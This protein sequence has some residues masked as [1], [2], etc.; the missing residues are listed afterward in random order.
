MVLENIRWSQSARVLVLLSISCL[1]ATVIVWGATRSSRRQADQAKSDEAQTKAVQKLEGLRQKY[2]AVRSV[3]IAAKAIIHLDGANARSGSGSYEYWAD[4][5]RYRIKCYTDPHLELVS[6]TEFAYDGKRFYFLDRK[7]GIL[8]YRVQDELRSFAAL[9]NPLFLPVDFLSGDDDDC[10]FCAL[11]LPEFKSKSERWSKRIEGIAVKASGKD[12]SATEDM[13][14]L[15]MPGGILERRAFKLRLHVKENP[16]GSMR[17]THI[18][19]VGPDGKPLTSITFDN[20][21]QTA[22]GDFPRAIEI[23]AFDESANTT[24]RIEYVINTLEVD[25]PID[26]KLFAIRFEE[27]EGVWDSD[28]KRFV[29]EKPPKPKA[30]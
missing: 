22:L 20:F 7:S 11:R 4:G 21:M 13:T 18:E 23:K 29:K 14:E 9:P 3:H 5:E 30:P 24:L 2:A 12:K 25:Q 19:R 26:D 27:A 28:E 10:L 17:P 16:D 8:S 1:T 15:E 6:D